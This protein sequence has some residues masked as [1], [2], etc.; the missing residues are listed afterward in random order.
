MSSPKQLPSAAGARGK[1]EL[2]VAAAVLAMMA[3]LFLAPALLTSRV[4]LPTDLLLS[5][6][7]WT[8]SQKMVAQNANVSDLVQQYYPYLW[9][10]RDQVRKGCFPLWNPY[11]LAGTPFLANIVSA[12]L[13]PVSWLVL[14]IPPQIFFEWTAW[15]KI[16]LAGLGMYLFTRDALGV[17][18]LS[19]WCA[20]S[21]YC[22]CGYSVYFLGFPN[23]YVSMLVPWVWWVSE[24]AFFRRDVRLR[25]VYALLAALMLAAGHV[26]SAAVILAFGILYVAIRVLSAGPRYMHGPPVTIRASLIPCIFHTVW[27]AL[28]AA[29]A[30]VPFVFYLRESSTWGARTQPANLFHLSWRNLPA[31]V[32]PYF[33]GSP[34]FHPELATIGQMEQVIFV[35]AV[36]LLLAC[37]GLAASNDRVPSLGLC[38]LLS[39][40]IP[41]GV[42]PVF[43]WFTSIPVLKQG[44]HMHLVQ[45][46]QFFLISFSALGLERWS[47][48]SRRVRIL[49]QL[50][51]LLLTVLLLWQWHAYKNFTFLKF[52]S[53]VP[54]YALT[55]LAA[56]FV[57][58]T[59]QLRP[60]AAPQVLSLL[61]PLSGFL[62]GFY[63]NPAKK[64]EYLRAPALVEKIPK[65]ARVAGI[66]VGTLLPELA[67][68]YRLRD[69]RGYEPVVLER[70]QALFDKLTGNI[71]DPQHSI[72]RTDS[73]TLETLKSCGVDY[74]ISPL[75]I[76]GASLEAVVEHQGFLYRLSDN[77]GRGVFLSRAKRMEPARALQ[78]LL[79]GSPGDMLFLEPDA[80][81]FTFDPMAYGRAQ[82]EGET[83]NELKFRVHATGP[84]F[85]LV[86]ESYAH[87]W[88]AWVNENSTQILHGN[89]LFMAVPV[90]SGDSVVQLRYRPW[91]WILGFCLTGF[92]ALVVTGG[93]VFRG[94]KK[95]PRQRAP[96]AK[97]E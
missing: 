94:W 49:P 67:V 71:S 59:T 62:F 4:L 28:L 52:D 70:T 74:L 75:P 23:G 41:F 9:F 14:V 8:A 88:S 36:P 31:L 82:I 81:S 64:P 80:N 17:R 65:Q 18:P 1:Y 86:R 33:H 78:E 42:W 35:G 84:G 20:A 95:P 6:P 10:F 56:L 87:G 55:S 57:F 53:H 68:T 48:S 29:A 40:L 32:I 92:S 11:A 58:A 44:N 30:W 39:F 93:I 83:A 66:G 77:A 96:D 60:A 7:P 43:Q 13:F 72:F 69:F 38:L 73:A 5:Y 63:F 51:I 47:Q 24:A 97:V 61:L 54:W 21:A 45:L 89:Y 27:G 26:E 12:V 22:F 76:A 19:A 25:W 2:A 85:L 79:K 3:A 34:V 90:G 50:F 16:F 37:Y 91:S 15:L 46:F